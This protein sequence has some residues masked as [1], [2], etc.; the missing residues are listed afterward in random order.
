MCPQFGLIAGGLVDGTVNLWN[1]AKIVGSEGSEDPGDTS[2]G[3][4]LASLQKHSGGVR[5]ETQPESRF[6]LY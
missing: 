4:L 5:H 3:A 1:P 6:A 2:N